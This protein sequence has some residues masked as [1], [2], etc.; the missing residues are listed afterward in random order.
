MG[1]W[2][3]WRAD[4]LPVNVNPDRVP[5][6]VPVYESTT[7][8]LGPKSGAGPRVSVHVTVSALIRQSEDLPSLVILKRCGRPLLSPLAEVDVGGT[9]IPPRLAPPELQDRKASMHRATSSAV[10]YRPPKVVWCR[11]ALARRHSR[12]SPEHDGDGAAPAIR[13]HD[14][15]REAPKGSS[16]PAAARAARAV[17]GASRFRKGVSLW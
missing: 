15:G 2:V 4:H 14:P 6:T 16:S 8:A 3:T 7:A 5:V 12:R 10:T 17:L 9:G 1:A 13:T 11:S